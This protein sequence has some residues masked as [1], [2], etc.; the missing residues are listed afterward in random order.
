MSGKNSAAARNIKNTSSSAIKKTSE[1]L[2]DQHQHQTLY[3]TQAPPRIT[4]ASS[5]FLEVEQLLNEIKELKATVK[6]SESGI[7]SLL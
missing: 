5:Q 6:N 3:Q 7:S 2:I 4:A 1:E